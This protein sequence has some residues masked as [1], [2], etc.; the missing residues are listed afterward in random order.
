MTVAGMDHRFRELGYT[1]DRSED[2]RCMAK[3]MTGPYAGYS[4][5]CISCGV[6]EVDTG[7]SAFHFESRRDANFRSMQRLR[8]EVF[9][10]TRGAILEA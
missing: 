7:R 10:V 3:Y 1:L 4:H 2:C 6:K 5:P 8:Q 9:A